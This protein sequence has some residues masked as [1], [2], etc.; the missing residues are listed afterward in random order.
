MT[1]P[2][3][4]EEA[5]GT[6]YEPLWQTPPHWPDHVHMIP[7]N[8]FENMGIDGRNRLYW[9]GVPI[10]TKNTVQLE[11]W[12]LLFAAVAT[13]ATAFSAVWPVALK[14]HWFGW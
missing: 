4:R 7:L 8:A 6:K 14:F 10:V 2:R 3:T 1:I 12:S 13:A 5:K 9:D 11:G